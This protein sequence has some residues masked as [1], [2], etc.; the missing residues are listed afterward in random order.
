[1]ALAAHGPALCSPCS[2]IKDVNL[3]Q[4]HLDIWYR[5]LCPAGQ[6][7]MHAS[8]LGGVGGDSWGQAGLGTSQTPSPRPQG[9]R[10]RRVPS[11]SVQEAE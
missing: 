3:D 5:P 1:M 2:E 4:L 10:R 8:A 11:G 7:G 6:G 9:S